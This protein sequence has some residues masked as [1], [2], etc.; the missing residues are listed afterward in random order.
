MNGVNG[1]V[2][3]FTGKLAFITRKNAIRKVEEH[4]GVCDK[5]VTKKTSYVVKG[6][7]TLEHFL[8]NTKSTKLMKAENYI[9]KGLPIKIIDENEFFT[10]INS[11][12]KSYKK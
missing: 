5:N 7:E 3:V 1:K 9:S 11:K 8:T 10:L 12:N 4:G 6:L 2:F